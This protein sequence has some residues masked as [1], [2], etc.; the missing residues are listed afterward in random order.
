MQYVVRLAADEPNNCFVVPD[1]RE[2]P[3]FCNLPIVA[4]GLAD[5]RWYCGIAIVT[6]EGNA[7]GTLFIVDDEPHEEDI[8]PIQRNGMEI[9]SDRS[10]RFG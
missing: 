1:L 7:I 6:G 5:Y 10:I 9:H 4:G 2:A 8:T 3:Q